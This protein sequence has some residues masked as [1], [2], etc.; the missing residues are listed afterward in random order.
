MRKIHPVGS[1][2]FAFFFLFAVMIASAPVAAQA[3]TEWWFLGGSDNGNPAH[4]VGASLNTDQTTDNHTFVGFFERVDFTQTGG[5]LTVQD[6]HLHVSQNVGTGGSTYFMQGG[7]LIAPAFKVGNEAQGHVVHTGGTVTVGDLYVAN[8]DGSGGSGANLDTN[9]ALSTYEIS[10]NSAILNVSGD[11]ILG[12]AAR[13][14][15]AKMIINDGVVTTA[16]LYVGNYGTGTL[17]LNNGQMTVTDKIVLGGGKN[18]GDTLESGAPDGTGTLDMSGGRL[19]IG[20]GG[21]S[22]GAGSATINLRGNWGASPQVIIGVYDGGTGTGSHEWAADLNIN[23]Y[24]GGS[25]FETSENQKITIHSTLSR[26]PGAGGDIRILKIGEGVLELTG[27]NTGVWE[28]VNQGILRRSGG[29]CHATAWV[30][31][32]WAFNNARYELTGGILYG[33]AHIGVANHGEMTVSDNGRIQNNY[34]GVGF[35]EN[36][37]GVLNINNGGI[38]STNWLNVGKAGCQSTVNLNS[39]GTLQVRNAIYKEGESGYSLINLAGGTIQALDDFEWRERVNAN[40]AAGTNTIFDTNGRTVTIK[41]NLSFAGTGTLTKTGDGT[42]VFD[43]HTDFAGQL[44][45]DRGTVAL[46]RSHGSG[47]VDDRGAFAPGA[48]ILIKDGG[49]LSQE[50]NGQYDSLGHGTYFPELTIQSGGLLT[51][52]DA[53]HMSLEALTLEGGTISSTGNHSMDLIAR[54]HYIFNNTVTVKPAGTHSMIT[55]DGILLQKTGSGVVFDVQDGAWLEITSWIGSMSGGPD[56]GI[57]NLNKTGTGT[58]ELSGNNN[59]SQ[60]DVYY[61]RPADENVLAG[62]LIRSG[63]TS[64][65]NIFVG[66][67]AG[68]KATYQMKEETASNPSAVNIS[69]ITLGGGGANVGTFLMDGGYVET[70]GFGIHSGSKL[71]ISDGTIWVKNEFWLDG[72]LETSG[73]ALWIPGFGGGSGTVQ[74]GG[75]MVATTGDGFQWNRPTT[76][77]ADTN[78]TI[79]TN[80]QTI[81]VTDG[82][83]FAGTGTL[84]KTGD[85]TLVFDTHTDFAGLL[86]INQGTVSLAQQHDVNGHGAFAPESRI[87]IESG[88]TLSLDGQYDALGYWDNFPQML[89]IQSGGLLFID[90][91]KHQS[92]GAITLEGG[93]ITSRGSHD[94]SYIADAHYIFDKTVTVLPATGHSKITADGILLRKYESGS[95]EVYFDVQG[96][97]WLEIT[98]WIGGMSGGDGIA[99]Q[100]INKTGTGTLELSG[101][102]NKYNDSAYI[103]PSN[104]N[105]LAGTLIRS[106][107]TTNGWV[108]VATGAGQTGNYVLKGGRIDNPV[109]NIGNPDGT[110]VGTFSLQGGTVKTDWYAQYAGSTLEVSLDLASGG[111]GISNSVI[112]VVYGLTLDA[113]A[114]LQLVLTEALVDNLTEDWSA[115]IFT[116]GNMD[117]ANGFAAGNIFTML[118]DGTLLDGYQWRYDNG[119]VYFEGIGESGGDV[120][121]PAAWVLMFLGLA[122]MA[123]LV[124]RRRRN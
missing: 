10:S 18:V 57:Q 86:V 56:D 53:R 102:N 96:D 106:G 16:N 52:S 17:E 81:K 41:D 94:L 79:H 111:G 5:T 47:G 36:R 4:H 124:R 51:V 115:Q 73:G 29:A 37:S 112:D 12:R 98:S 91:D 82:A 39:G 25:Y 121:E 93:E 44:I 15:N 69:N 20:S 104:E 32:D 45:I 19:L 40:V 80:G 77:L 49:I 27:V 83:S 100:D 43:Q 11:L 21:V 28:I 76:V 110:G 61:L 58:L 38:V 1:F 55:A 117:N 42:L 87:L 70:N 99:T 114:I 35:N 101:D 90:G 74:L 122:G 105:V 68:D 14:T 62:T 8:G 23:F 33:D 113:D 71:R 34:I 85:G 65:G 92:L 66:G 6:G 31:D 116:A 3:P 67:P 7:T 123:G 75:G 2:G 72:S 24:N 97:A 89:T 108:N 60:Y 48:S 88:G 30:G 9:T 107:G 13:C 120:P 119:W 26:G 54:A 46:V 78:T 109:I 63:G 64:N 118:G 103:R 95:P 59:V 50:G 84:T 22:K